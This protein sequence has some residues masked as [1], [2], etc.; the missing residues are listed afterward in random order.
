MQN[1][2][3]LKKKIP[4]TGTLVRKI[5]YNAK[6][7]NIYNNI[8]DNSDFDTKL[9]STDRKVTSNK[10]MQ[11]HTEAKLNSVLLPTKSK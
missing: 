2:Q 3:I 1:P 4:D 7:T 5:D 6:T 9:W 11:V 8:P 10:I